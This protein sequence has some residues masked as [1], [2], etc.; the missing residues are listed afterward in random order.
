[1]K[2]DRLAAMARPTR[3]VDDLFAIFPDLPGIPYR[4]AAEQIEKVHR[5]VADTRA[6]A[7]E[8]ILR[9]KAASAR[10]RAAVAGR[11]RR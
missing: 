9:Q 8:N 6:R 10:V 1:M 4:T 3:H 2:T 5:Q 7:R 11:K